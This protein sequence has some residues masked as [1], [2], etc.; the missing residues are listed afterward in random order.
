MRRGFHSP[1]FSIDF[2]LT[3]IILKVGNVVQPSLQLGE[4]KPGERGRRQKSMCD[5][6]LT[7][8]STVI[9]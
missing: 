3:S 6:A 4:Q 9:V 7:K 1:T 2:M 8:T 5:C